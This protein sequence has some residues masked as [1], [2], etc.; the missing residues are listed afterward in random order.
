MSYCYGPVVKKTF[1]KRI[2]PGTKLQTREEKHDEI[3]II[4]KLYNDE[5]YAILCGGI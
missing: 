2:F 4:F 1:C 3:Y 5:Q